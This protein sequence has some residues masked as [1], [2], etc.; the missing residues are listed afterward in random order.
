MLA[1]T[2]RHGN[3][4]A[5]FSPLVAQ[6]NILTFATFS[7]VKERASWI[8]DVNNAAWQCSLSRAIAAWPMAP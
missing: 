8:A 4:S 6:R 2:L 5:T 3:I 7:M 1:Q